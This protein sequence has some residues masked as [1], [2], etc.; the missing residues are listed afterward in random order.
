MAN[1]APGFFFYVRDFIADTVHM[2]AEEV[3]AY[4]LILCAAWDA[5]RCGYLDNES[6]FLASVGRLNAKA[7][8]RCSRAIMRALK[9]TDD[10]K[11]VYS[12]R[13]VEVFNAQDAKRQQAAEAGRKSV[14]AKAQR[15]TIETPTTVERPLVERSNDPTNE[16]PT[17]VNYSD[18]DSSADSSEKQTHAHARN[19]TPGPDPERITRAA[20]WSAW[21]AAGLGDMQDGLGMELLRAEFNREGVVA[22]PVKY[23]AAWKRISTAWR[24]KI[25]TCGDGPLLMKDHLDKCTLVV[26]GEMNPDAVPKQ[27]GPA[28]YTLPAERA[29][30]PKPF[31]NKFADEEGA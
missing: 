16:T 1:V 27:A 20:W 21:K 23:C 4:W 10:G 17:K 26:N 2:S 13:M 28:G 6:E 18:S 9:T 15:R 22:D 12:K 3:G 11:H 30:Q 31:T 14:A 29:P 7:W 19:G 5:E 24:R 8:A 25:P